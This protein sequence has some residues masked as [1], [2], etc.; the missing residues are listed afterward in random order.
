[1]GNRSDRWVS[2][3]TRQTLEDA[4]SYVQA[5][6]LLS[7]TTILAPVYFILG[8]IKSDEVN[9]FCVQSGAEKLGQWATLSRTSAFIFLGSVAT[10]VRCG[11]IFSDDCCIFLLNIM[12]NNFENRSAFS[13]FIC[14]SIVVCLFYSQCH[15]PR[16]F[17]SPYASHPR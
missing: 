5:K 11:G 2:F 4:T 10:H 7:N 15:W 16:F 8:G 13:E 6:Q 17:M 1:M 12:L 9:C 3:L 14:K